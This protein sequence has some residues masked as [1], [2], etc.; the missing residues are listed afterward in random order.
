MKPLMQAVVDALDFFISNPVPI[1]NMRKIPSKCLIIGSG[2]AFL[3]GKILFKDRPA[4]FCDEGRYREIL[5]LYNDREAAIVISASGEKH[6]P[7]IVDNL[8]KLHP[9][10]ELFLFTCN[11]EST[12][13]KF[14]PKENV[15]ITPSIQEPI[16]YNTSTYVGMILGKTQEDP[17]LIKQHLIKVVQEKIRSIKFEDYKAF[18]ILIDPKYDVVREMFVTKF[19]EL[20]GGRVIGRCYTSEQTYHA[21]TVVPW[22]KELFISIGYENNTFGTERL[23]IPLLDGA[24]F[25][26]VIAT[27]YYIVGTIQTRFPN[28]FEQNAEAYAILQKRWFDS[29]RT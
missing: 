19:D 2:N 17:N 3:T 24:N 23:I 29:M 20:F 12:A 18:Y 1:L 22:D 13:A 28:W 7:I 27:G 16:T 10:L 6:A 9:S 21:K 26:A 5:D 25:A 15:F 11:G 8:M 14:L 4:I